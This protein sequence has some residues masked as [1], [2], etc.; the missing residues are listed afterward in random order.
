ML[1][2]WVRTAG[3]SGTPLQSLVARDFAAFEDALQAF[4]Q[5]GFIL[6]GGG[7]RG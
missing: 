4:A 6:R 7:G 3:P 1:A 2:R 5:H